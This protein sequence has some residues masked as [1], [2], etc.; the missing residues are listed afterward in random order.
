MVPGRNGACHVAMQ[1][2]HVR[3]DNPPKEALPPGQQEVNM[4]SGPGVCPLCVLC[5]PWSRPQAWRRRASSSVPSSMIVRSAVAQ[6][7]RGGGGGEHGNGLRAA[8]QCRY[9]CKHVAPG[10]LRCKVQAR[11]DPEAHPRS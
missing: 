10:A 9:A 6:G 5:A 1:R 8:R 7:K 2:L 11:P 4:G 3:Q